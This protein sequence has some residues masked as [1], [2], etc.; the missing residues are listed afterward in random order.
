MAIEIARKIGFQEAWDSTTVFFVD[1][2][3][4]SEIDTEVE[5]LLEVAKDERISE[6]ALINEESIASFLTAHERSLDVILCDIELSAE[7]FMR[8]VTLLRKLGRIDGGFDYTNSEWGITKIKSKIRQDKSF[9]HQIARLLV[10][11]KDDPELEQYIPR[12]Y[13]ETLNYKEIKGSSLAARRVRY[14]HSLIG[15]YGGKKGYKVEER[16]KK[17]LLA[18]RDQYGIPFNQGRSRLIDTDIDFAV[19]GTD[20]PWVIIMSSFQET[21]SSGQ[22]TKARDMLQAYERIN[23]NNSRYGENRAFVNFVDGGG[24]L[25]RKRDL[26]R[27]VDQCHYFINLSYLDMLES[28]VLKHVHH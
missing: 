14:K 20:S 11:G 22:T 5:A 10:C 13:L 18:I 6:H 26:E 16:I 24:W 17:K 4:E 3:L 27:L 12:Y 9:A 8:I 2:T 15:T 28:I 1:E 7:K 23:R 21:T 25:A 19:P